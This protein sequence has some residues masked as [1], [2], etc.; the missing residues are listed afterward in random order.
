MY[1]KD[2]KCTKNSPKGVGVAA[3]MGNGKAVAE[4]TEFG[5]LV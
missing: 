4:V 1:W 2:A 5:L 3:D